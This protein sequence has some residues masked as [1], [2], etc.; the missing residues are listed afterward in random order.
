MRERRNGNYR[1][2]SEGIDVC[3]Y[4]FMPPRIN[5]HK[6]IVTRLRKTASNI[7]CSSLRRYTF[8]VFSRTTETLG[9]SKV[10]KAKV[11]KGANCLKKK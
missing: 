10:R 7:Q 8:K 5:L 11:S 2:I 4:I 9:C 1:D 6:S 3:M